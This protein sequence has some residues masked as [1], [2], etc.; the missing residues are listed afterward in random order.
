MLVGRERRENEGNDSHEA[1]TQTRHA[2]KGEI[3]KTGAD[4]E[5]IGKLI[6]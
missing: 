4:L 1:T 3:K 2:G 6:G 5:T